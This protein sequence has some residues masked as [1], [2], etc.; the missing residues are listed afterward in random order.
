MAGGQ[1]VS[2]ANIAA[3]ALCKKH[4]IKVMLDATRAVENAY[5][6]KHA[7]TGVRAQV[8]RGDP[9]EICSYTDGCTELGEEGLPGQ[10]R[11]ISCA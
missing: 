11:R 9:A 8:D 10:H 6:I 1:P 5:F 2:M 4:G 3:T 7:R